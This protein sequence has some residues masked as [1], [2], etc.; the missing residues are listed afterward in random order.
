MIEKGIIRE[1]AK[2]NLID[3]F[4]ILR[5]YLQVVFLKYLYSAKE[6]D[7]ILSKGGTIIHLFLGSFRYSEDLDFTVAGKRGVLD[8]VLERTLESMKMEIEGV[9]FNSLKTTKD[10]YSLR[11]RYPEEGSRIPITI[12]LEFSL[13]DKPLT[14]KTSL[15]ETPFPVSPYP[16]VVHLGWEEILAEKIRALSVR[17]HGRDLFD[18]WFLLSK[19][20]RINWEM[21]NEKMK[22]YGKTLSSAEL[23]RKVKAF[24]EDRIKDD[25]LEFL[26]KSHR[27]IVDELKDL[28]YSR[29]SVSNR[30]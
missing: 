9:S 16:L 11:M 24:P 8:N 10:V 20:I 12:K 13:K 18:I 7:A 21:I 28:V 30:K 25:L 6:S 1:I 4:T 29:I 17:G 15:L 3:E 23:A 26:P 19:N 27:K 14:R 2:K 22:W 5:E